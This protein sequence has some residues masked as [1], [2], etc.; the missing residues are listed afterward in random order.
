MASDAP[1]FLIIVIIVMATIALAMIAIIGSWQ[2]AGKGPVGPSKGYL[3]PLHGGYKARQDGS[4]PR[5]H[6]NPPKAPEGAGG[7]SH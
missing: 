4:G 3:P 5:V 2:S 6:P 7:G 1:V